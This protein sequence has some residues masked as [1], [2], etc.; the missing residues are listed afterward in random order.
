MKLQTQAD[1]GTEQWAI[2][3]TPEVLT[4]IYD[5]AI[6]IAVWQR[7]LNPV[8]QQY[9]VE[10]LRRRKTI[11]LKLSGTPEQLLAEIRRVFPS[12]L[13]DPDSETITGEAF[14]SDVEVVID[15]FACLFEARILGLRINVLE[16]AMCPRFHTDNVG[17][18][19]I[20]TYHGLGTEWLPEGV[21]NRQALGT[22]HASQINTPG[23]IIADEQFIQRMNTGDVALFKGELWD[24]NEGRGIVHRS[25]AVTSQQP[26]RLVMTCDLIE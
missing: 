13:G 9:L 4:G 2:A 21:V 20:T 5:E 15:M 22:A 7:E 23:A 12:E 8:L 10:L 25:P 16:H 11:A 6:N 17:V 18:R 26:K 3:H 14:Y 19:L 1:L 24:G